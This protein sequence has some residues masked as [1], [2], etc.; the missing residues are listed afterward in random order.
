MKD[1]LA[2]LAELPTLLAASKLLKPRPADT[3]DSLGLR[4]QSNAERFARRSAL[5][6]EGQAL[7]WSQF[8]AEA[9][10][11]AAVFKAQGLSR[12]DAVSV[13]MDN[14]IEFL[15][16]VVALNKLGV[17]ASLINT[18]LT[19]HAL[20]HCVTISA[21]RKFVFGEEHIEA[22][23][24]VHDEL[25]LQ[26]GKDYLFVPD[27]GT[28]DA[29]DWAHDM[30]ALAVNASSQNPVETAA[31]TI[32]DTAFHIFTSGTTGL[33]KAALLSNRRY[34]TTADVVRVGGLK[35]TENDRLY[36]CLPLYHGTGLMVGAGAA[37]MAGASMFI[38][39]KFSASNFLPEV[40]EHRTTCFVYIGELCRYLLHTPSQ[41][42]D[43]D[44]PLR[45][46]VGNGLRPDIWHEFKR[47]FGVPRVAEF[48]GSS[49][50]NVGFFNLLNKDCTVGMSGLTT[51]LVRY[52]VDRDE[53]VRDAAGHCVRVANGEPGLL[54]GKITRETAFEGYTSAEATSS[55]IL[56]DVFEAGDSW[57]NSGD[58]MR[59]VDVGFSFG[60]KHY[61]FVDRIGDTFRWKGENVSTNEV[62]EIINAHPQVAVSNVYGVEIPG[63]DGRAGMAALRLAEGVEKLDLDD[64]SAHVCRELPSYARPVF[65]RIQREID[66][67]GTFKML[68]GELRKQGY[69]PQQ[70][71]DQL[72]VMKPGSSRYEPLDKSFYK[73]VREGKG[74]F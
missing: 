61:Q 15:V 51:A 45:A 18:N 70:V 74:G 35:C 57:F 5:V 60:L 66:T 59:T 26:T 22:V 39:R 55:K 29:P 3:V 32:S 42:N 24:G 46:V 40:R 4:V 30:A 68:K 34:L 25:A 65:L 33:P 10:R 58:L 20:A 27:L 1:V 21:A 53:I 48:Y 41:P 63:A 8:N 38:R 6:F 9:N 16:V 28:V 12:G 47:R 56:R 23:A 14:R 43:A 71:A 62:G 73:Q 36:L 7:N 13:L 67:T 54:L 50:G 72:C 64:F 44:N 2:T 31:V 49:E 19:G 69:D 52:D 11:Y 37:F 17:V